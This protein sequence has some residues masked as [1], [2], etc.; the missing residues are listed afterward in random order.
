MSRYSE[1]TCKGAACFRK[2]GQEPGQ[3]VAADVE[4]LQ[5]AGPAPVADAHRN[6]GARR[7]LCLASFSAESGRPRALHGWLVVRALFA[8]TELVLRPRQVITLIMQ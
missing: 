6:F 3:A 1:F 7:V 2:H 5:A 8:R 4:E